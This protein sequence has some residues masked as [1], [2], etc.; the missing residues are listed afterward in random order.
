M[1]K[2][3]VVRPSRGL[4]EYVK[5]LRPG[6]AGALLIGKIVT[7]ESGPGGNTDEGYTG[8]VFTLCRLLSAER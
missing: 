4:P 6:A 3:S 7:L 5:L 2:D 1:V 8:R